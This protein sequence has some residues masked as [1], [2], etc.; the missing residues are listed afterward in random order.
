MTQGRVNAALEAVVSIAVFDSDGSPHTVDAAIDTGFNDRLALPRDMV[1]QLHLPI[2]G[3]A[4]VLLGDGVEAELSTYEA[5]VAWADARLTIPVIETVGAALI[6][7]ELLRGARLT[8]VYEEGGT[9][10]IDPL[11]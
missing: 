10:A 11:T 1:E 8:I 4:A 5:V 3:H 2:T 7:T 9:V 6:G